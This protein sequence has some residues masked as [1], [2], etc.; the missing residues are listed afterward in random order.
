[1]A[2]MMEAYRFYNSDNIYASATTTGKP[3]SFGGISGRTES[4]GLGLYYC[5]REFLND[6]YYMNPLGLSAGIRDKTMIVQGFG[7][8]GYWASNFLEKDGAKLLGVI[9]R[10]GAIFNESGISVDE[11]KKH[12]IKKGTLKGF[13]K[14]QFYED[15][16]DVFK[17]PCDVLIPAAVERSITGS[18]AVNFQCKIVAEGGNGPTTP[19]GED[20]LTAKGVLVLP[21]LLMNAGG[22]TVSYFEYVKNLGFIRPG[23]LTRK[24][25]SATNKWIFG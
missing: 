5:L 10:D 21:D 17:K 3:V 2:W 9:E 12:L 6:P 20:V 15:V 7:N 13:P 8:V 4:T 1:M 11:V 19:R 22:V 23:M 25:E 24:L 14:A 18:N 16:Q